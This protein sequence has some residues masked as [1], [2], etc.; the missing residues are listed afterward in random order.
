[1]YLLPGG[2]TG[3]DAM[4]D[5]CPYRL[6]RTL[7]AADVVDA[8]KELCNKTD[9]NDYQCGHLNH[10]PALQYF[11]LSLREQQYVSPEHSRN[12]T[13]RSQIRHVRSEATKRQLFF[14][15]TFV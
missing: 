10:L 9:S 13:R 11:D 6:L 4:N 5:L 7:S 12:R 3:L 2:L 1:M 8:A 14:A 15:A